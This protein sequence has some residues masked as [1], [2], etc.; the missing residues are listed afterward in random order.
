LFRVSLAFRWLDFLRREKLMSVSDLPYPQWQ[1]PL[2]RA[3]MELRPDSLT[4]KIKI[5]ET[6]IAQRL[7]ECERDRD[8]KSEEEWGALHDAASTLGVL[9]NILLQAE[10][11]CD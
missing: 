2:L 11:D 3:V 9:K 8:S 6:A 5:A 7:R 1:K 10:R 4:E